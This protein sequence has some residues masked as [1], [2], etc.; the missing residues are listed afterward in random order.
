MVIVNNQAKLRELNRQ[1]KMEHENAIIKE[2][3]EFLVPDA[4]AM[5][6]RVLDLYIRMRLDNIHC[7]SVT[8]ALTSV[9]ENLP[10]NIIEKM[11]KREI[12]ITEGRTLLKSSNFINAPC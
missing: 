12:I 7:C 2:A 8:S 3:I 9:K 6:Q 1:R 4:T 11:E 10:K 5:E